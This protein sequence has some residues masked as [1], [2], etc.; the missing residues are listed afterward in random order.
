MHFKIWGAL[1][2]LVHW[3]YGELNHWGRVTH[4]CFSRPTIIGLWPIQ[5]QTIIRINARILHNSNLRNTF[6][7]NLKQNSYIFIQENAIENIVCELAV[8]LSRPQ[9]VKTN[10]TFKICTDTVGLDRTDLVYIISHEI[11]PQFFS[12]FFIVVV[13]GA[14][15][16]TWSHIYTYF[17]GN[18]YGTTVTE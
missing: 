10:H 6:Q 18:D 15:K 5:C 12:I 4:M 16:F 3:S 1:C 13:S 9:C 8:I 17:N 14:M 2:P 7:W 11:S